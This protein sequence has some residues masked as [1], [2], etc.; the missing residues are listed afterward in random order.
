MEGRRRISS[1][2]FQQRCVSK[3]DIVSG[4]LV[5]YKPRE[6]PGV[7]AIVFGSDP[8]DGSPEHVEFKA[9]YPPVRIMVPCRGADDLF[10]RQ[11]VCLVAT[12]GA[13]HGVSKAYL[14]AHSEVLDE[15]F[16]SSHGEELLTG[17]SS[18]AIVGFL[19]MLETARCG[20]KSTG[21]FG[22]TIVHMTGL[23]LFHKWDVKMPVRTD[24]S[25]TWLNIQDAA[26]LL[27]LF[28]KYD[29][30]ELKSVVLNFIGA[31]MKIQSIPGVDKLSPELFEEVLAADADIPASA[32]RIRLNP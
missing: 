19:R 15:M 6:S 27:T 16:Q 18:E 2:E 3:D 25:D 5:F 32:K 1:V 7:S 21:S 8:E 22:N 20:G 12:C 29:Q 13:Q 31:T 26:R 28:D 4:G 17:A 23:E 30:K 11:D 10:A 9:E 24:D 14:A